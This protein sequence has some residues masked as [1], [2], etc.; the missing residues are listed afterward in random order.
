MQ[1]EKLQS[2]F[3]PIIASTRTM[4]LLVSI[5]VMEVVHRYNSGKYPTNPYIL[6]KDAYLS[7][8]GDI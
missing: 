3:F 4:N 1:I 5:S 2:I 8:S 7:R 6:P